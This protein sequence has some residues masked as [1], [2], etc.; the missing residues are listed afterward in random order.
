M[1]VRPRA[2]LK[3]GEHLFLAAMPTAGT[4]DNPHAAYEGRKGGMIYV[5]SAKD[6]AKVSELKLEA[7]PVWDGMAAANGKLFVSTA[8]GSIRCF[9]P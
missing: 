7:P 3:S 5:A 9:G 2:I 1:P 6:G 8:D 4:A